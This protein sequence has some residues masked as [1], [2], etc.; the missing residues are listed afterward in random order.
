[1]NK[2]FW[3]KVNKNATIVILQDLSSK[4]DNGV[5]N[6]YIK[7]NF[8]VINREFLG[9]FCYNLQEAPSFLN[10]ILGTLVVNKYKIVIDIETIPNIKELNAIKQAPNGIAILTHIVEDG[11]QYNNYKLIHRINRK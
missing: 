9:A 2:N 5:I 11:D 1:M 4:R 10:I 7:G 3:K 6:T 8:I